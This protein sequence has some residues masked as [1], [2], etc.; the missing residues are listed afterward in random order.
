MTSHG[1]SEQKLSAKDKKNLRFRSC[2]LPCLSIFPDLALTL[3]L[4]DP[5]SR[6]YVAQLLL[7]ICK[8][9]GSLGYL[10]S[11]VAVIIARTAAQMHCLL[12]LSFA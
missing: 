6:G 7:Q 8:L 11:S 12:L 9:V 3:A 1:F 4:F 2:M 10:Q 5:V